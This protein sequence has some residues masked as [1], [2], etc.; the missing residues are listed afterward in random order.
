MEYGTEINIM[1]FKCPKCSSNYVKGF[2]D[3]KSYCSNPECVLNYHE[4][5][6]IDWD[7]VWRKIRYSTPS[8]VYYFFKNRLFMRYDLIKTGLSK[9]S[10]CDKDYLLLEGMMG[11]LVD[12][13][14]SEEPFDV[15]TSRPEHLD[16][17]DRSTDFGKREYVYA[18]QQV[19][20]YQV[21]L[22]LY[23]DWKVVYPKMQA[24]LHE[25]LMT[26]SEDKYEAY[27]D[28]EN[29]L[30]QFEQEMLHRLV[31]IRKGMWT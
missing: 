6:T 22:N 21:F 13:V 20:A 1:K 18:K 7:V 31:D 26:S 10:W 5:K 2:R 4:T 9:S 29:K 19:E 17:I 23:V 11:M 16:K 8:D 28:Y 24:R 15:L 14:E 12:Y 25:L 27:W 3:K 30:D